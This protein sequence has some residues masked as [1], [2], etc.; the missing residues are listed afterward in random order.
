[1]I[2]REVQLAFK[3]NQTKPIIERFTGQSTV[4]A[5]DK[6]LLLIYLTLTTIFKKDCV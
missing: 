6:S 1:M 5:T 4:N 3:K 2:F